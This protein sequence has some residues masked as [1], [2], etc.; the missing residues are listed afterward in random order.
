M[1]HLTSLMKGIGATF[2]SSRSSS[3]VASQQHFREVSAQRCYR[4]RMNSKDRIDL[5]PE[6]EIYQL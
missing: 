2:A 4:R 3:T 5:S 1:G 6:H